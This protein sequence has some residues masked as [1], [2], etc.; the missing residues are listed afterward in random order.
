MAIEFRCTQCE[1]L[2]RVPEDSAGKNARC[3][4]CQALM[5]VPMPGGTANEP[6][7][8]P[9]IVTPPLSDPFAAAGG[10]GS[11]LP[12]KPPAPVGGPFGDAGA[13]PFGGAPGQSANPYASPTA[14]AYQTVV[15]PIDSLPIVPRP[16]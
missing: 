5:I 15:S 6:A 2:L 13:T 8:P 10:G 9:P 16:A 14:A 4:K 3:P 7:A 11:A 12:P 1:Q